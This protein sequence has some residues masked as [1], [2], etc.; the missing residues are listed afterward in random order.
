MKEA[1]CLVLLSCKGSHAQLLMVK[2]HAWSCP[3]ALSMLGAPPCSGQRNCG[4]TQPALSPPGA[5]FLAQLF[6]HLVHRALLQE[7]LQVHPSGGSALLSLSVSSAPASAKSGA[8]RRLLAPADQRVGTRVGCLVPH[9]PAQPVRS[10]P[11]LR[12]S[13]CP[14]SLAGLLLAPAGV[15]CSSFKSSCAW[16]RHWQTQAHLNLGRTVT[17]VCSCR[18]G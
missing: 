17:R 11:Q 2:E 14:V 16:H 4:S 7:A 6:E 10:G 9:L 5:Q 3:S 15:R 1:A 8:H 12:M 18:A 13:R